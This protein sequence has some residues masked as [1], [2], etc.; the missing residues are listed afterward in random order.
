MEIQNIE[1]E[2]EE[3]KLKTSSNQQ[4]AIERIVE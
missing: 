4:K 1:E 3:L 2:T